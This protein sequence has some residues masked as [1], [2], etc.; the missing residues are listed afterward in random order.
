MSE[1][2]ILGLMRIG[3]KD[4]IEN[5]YKYG[6]IYMNDIIS[7]TKIEKEIE[8]DLAE[9]ERKDEYEGIFS[10][11]Q[12]TYGKLQIDEN[13]FIEFSETGE[14]TRFKGTGIVRGLSQDLKGNIYCMYAFTSELCKKRNTVDRRVYKFGPRLVLITNPKEFVRRVVAAI[15]KDKFKPDKDLV[16]YYDENEN[17][18]NLSVFDKRSKYEHQSEYRF[19]FKNTFDQF[20]KFYIGSIEDISH[21][22]DTTDLERMT[23]G[24][25]PD[26][27]QFQYLFYDSIIESILVR[28]PFDDI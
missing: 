11:A 25:N 15:K 18:I 20:H 7:F 2:K 17:H 22:C 26:T 3:Q 28:Y 5:L 1:N 23:F 10:L 4:H 16:R 24:L 14:N 13:N 6:E 9:D 12:V 27:G 8:E 19:F 21:I